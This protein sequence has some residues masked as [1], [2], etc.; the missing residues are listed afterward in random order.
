MLGRGCWASIDTDTPCAVQVA[1]MLGGRLYDC[2]C[3]FIP[4]D[5]KGEEAT[6]EACAAQ[7]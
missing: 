5:A 6:R 3:R 2:V 4:G 1:Q 7:R